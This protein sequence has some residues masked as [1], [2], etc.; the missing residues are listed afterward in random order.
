METEIQNDVHPINPREAFLTLAQAEDVLRYFGP[1]NKRLH[2]FHG[3]ARTS[4][5][6]FDGTQTIVAW[7]TDSAAAGASCY[8]DCLQRAGFWP[9]RFHVPPP[10]RFA[11]VGATVMYG[12]AAVCTARSNSMAKRIAAALNWYQPGK[13][14]T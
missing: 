6:L 12:T 14:G 9:D 8:E 1:D 10:V 5:H 2:F 7:G 11:S 4:V 13:R 3:G